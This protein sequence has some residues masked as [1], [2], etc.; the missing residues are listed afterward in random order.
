M[1]VM[2]YQWLERGD[3]CLH[4][5]HTLKSGRGILTLY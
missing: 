5:D 4:T 3:Y 1:H 2:T